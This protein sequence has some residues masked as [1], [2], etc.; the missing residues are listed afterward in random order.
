MSMAH[1]ILYEH[2]NFGGRAKHVF[3]DEAFLVDF[4]DLTSSFEV[5]DGHWQFFV[6][7][8]FNGQRGG[9]FGPH[10]CSW[11]EAEGIPNDTVSSVKLVG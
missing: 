9:T 10:R 7:A 11:V 2:I 4:N 8:H 6:D 3:H 5:V 1:L